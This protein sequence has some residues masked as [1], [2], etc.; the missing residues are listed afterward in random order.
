MLFNKIVKW[1]KILTLT[2]WSIMLI[3]NIC[4]W[5]A[6][7][8]FVMGWMQIFLHEGT[9]VSLALAEVMRDTL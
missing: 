8:V 2:L 5:A 3:G 6:G 7:G 9:I 4:T 1:C